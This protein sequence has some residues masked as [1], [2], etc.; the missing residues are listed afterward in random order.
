MQRKPKRVGH[1]KL[2]HERN[3]Q[4]K[5]R[6]TA[7]RPKKINKGTESCKEGNMFENEEVPEKQKPHEEEKN[8]Q[9]APHKEED[10]TQRKDKL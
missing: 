4:Q 3:S 7:Y 1:N 10:T 8:T 9:K 2:S 5:S 6:E